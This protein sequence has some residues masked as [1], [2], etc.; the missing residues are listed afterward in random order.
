[1]TEEEWL[2]SNNAQA[3]C[4]FM[5]STRTN[6]KS[7]WQGWIQ[8]KRFR[9]SERRWRLIE[10]ATCELVAEQA[11]IPGLEPLLHLARRHAEGHLPPAELRMAR[12]E[13]STWIDE[14]GSGMFELSLSGEEQA[15][16]VAAAMGR[17]LARVSSDDPVLSAQA[18][19]TQERAD[20]LRARL[21]LENLG[22]ILNPD[23]RDL[24]SVIRDILGNPF[25]PERIDP[26]WLVA[27]DGAACRL[28]QDIVANCSNSELPILADALEDA[29]CAS[30]AILSHCRTPQRHVR[31]CW[32]VDLLL[33]RE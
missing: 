5:Y 27:N 7:R 1:M 30:D 17:L 12:S 21:R 31:G 9:V 25:R 2:T 22:T 14:L 13:V 3:M 11:D 20:Q 15:Y 4:D 28:A 6:W 23:D 33:G 26:T 8:A 24:A 29:G 10:L 16:R 32:V 19:C 18:E